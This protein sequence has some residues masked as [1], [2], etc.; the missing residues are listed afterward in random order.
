MR[1]VFEYQGN[2]L[3]EKRSAHHSTDFSR[4]RIARTFKL[5]AL[6]SLCIKF[7]LPIKISSIIKCPYRRYKF[8]K[9]KKTDAFERQ[10]TRDYVLL[11]T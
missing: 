4:L 3:S 9:K 10:N 1:L 11:T 5:Y 8:Y 2:S 6:K 7:E